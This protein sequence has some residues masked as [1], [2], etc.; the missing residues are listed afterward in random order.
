MKKR[1]FMGS[2]FIVLAIVLG[3]TALYAPSVF[4]YRYDSAQYV[5]AKYGATIDLVAGTVGVDRVTLSAMVVQET[6]G[7]PTARGKAGELGLVQVKPGTLDTVNAWYGL[8][9]RY[10]DLPDPYTGLLAGALYLKMQYEKFGNYYLATAAYNA[11]PGNYRAGA[12]YAESVERIKTT[13]RII[14]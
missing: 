1:L 13:L 4:S 7:D 5:R 12:S 10:Q 9:I 2:A 8:G 6:A 14:I 3:V 11:G